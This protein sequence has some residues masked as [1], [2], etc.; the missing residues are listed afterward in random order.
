AAWNGLDT[1]ITVPGTVNSLQVVAMNAAGSAFGTSAGVSGP[2]PA[3]FPTQPASQRV[4]AGDS[5]VFSAVAAGPALTYQWLRDGRPLSNGTSGDG[6]ITGATGA[7]LVISG[8]TPASAGSYTCVATSF[9]NSVASDTATL[10]VGA[11]GEAGRLA[12]VS[13]RA[14]VRPGGGALIVGF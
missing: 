13:C 3:V 1:V 2:F 9:G 6:T 8:A 4:A 12:D 5:V 11:T 10:E 14:S 7:T